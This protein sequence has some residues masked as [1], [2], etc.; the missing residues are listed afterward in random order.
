MLLSTKEKQLLKKY[1]SITGIDEVGRGPLAGPVVTASYTITSKT[2]ILSA[3]N[4][5]KKLSEKKWNELYNKLISD[6]KSYHLGVSSN[7]IIDEYGIVYAIERAMNECIKNSHSEYILI[8]GIFKNEFNTKK[9]VETII[10]GDSLIYCIAAASI[11][12]K[13]ARDFIMKTLALKYPGFDFQKN[14]GY[15]SKFHIAQLKKLGPT[16]IHRISFIK[17]F[18]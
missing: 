10:K 17:N 7:I 2:P 8:D 13:V 15:G 6:K 5:S 1:N 14:K 12:A 9:S 4:D 3:V 16:E 18:I 11:I